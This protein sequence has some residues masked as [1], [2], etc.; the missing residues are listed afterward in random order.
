[1]KSPSLTKVMVR[2][3]SSLWVGGKEERKSQLGGAWNGSAKTTTAGVLWY[4][5]AELQGILHALA[6]LGPKALKDKTAPR[7]PSQRSELALTSGAR[8]DTHC[9]YCSDTVAPWTPSKL[10][11]NT[12]PVKVKSTVGPWGK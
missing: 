7:S 10:C 3:E 8:T 9:G 6:Q 5:E 2:F 11:L 12:T 1:M 4:G